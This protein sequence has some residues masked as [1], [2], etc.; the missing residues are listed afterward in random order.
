MLKLLKYFKFNKVIVNSLIIVILLKTLGILYVPT[1]TASIVN[2]GVIKGDINYVLKTGGIMIGIAI[3][4]GI[5]AILSTYFSANLSATLSRDMRRKLFFHSQKLSVEDYK[6]F[7]T[8]SLITRCTS[9]VNQVENTV[10]MIFEMIIPVPFITLIGMLL[11]FSKDKY[12]ALIILI[13]GLTLLIF[14][15]LISKRV[16]GLSIGMQEKL[17]KI[18]SRVRQF[19]S[20]IRII[21]AFNRDRHEKKLM[22]NAFESYAVINIKMNK[23]FAMGMPLIL[24]ILNLCTVAILWFGAVRINAGEML[25]GD[26][27]AVIEYAI[28]ILVYLVMAV[29]VLMNLPRASAC[30]KRI[31]EVLSYNPEIVD[32]KTTDLIL[33][34]NISLEFRNVTFSYKDAQEPVLKDIN[35]ICESGKTTAI[36]GATG[37]GKSTIGKLIP[38]LHDVEAGEILINDINIKKFSQKDL[39]N[40][41]SFS[42]QK[43]FLFS[44]TIASNIRHGKKDATSEEIRN[45][46]IT[47]QADNFI[48]ELKS[49][50]D[51]IVSQGGSNFSGGQKQR[52][53]IARAL[54]KKSDIYVFDDS[55]SALDYSTDARLRAA[56]KEKLKSSIVITI[57]QRISTIMEADQIIVLD[58]GQII[59]IGTHKELMK[60]CSIYIEIAKSQLSKEEL[61]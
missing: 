9:D 20:G 18:N 50:Y 37:S 42:P 51:S 26:I 29:M 21:R 27:M 35:F 25:V 24:F 59:G 32:E 54:I 36:I 40:M 34:N 45:A 11:A 1:L 3:F 55:F 15:L 43:A 41:I 5:L 44:G 17:D 19:I 39:R 7:S 57:A 4:T 10:I 14:I 60:N 12:M 22:D 31:L 58:K 30:S 49:D 33:N 47:A 28:I 13:T 46:A 16:I 52:I 56:M 6:K 61:A 23:I 2:N 48:M 53:C 38:R 8:S